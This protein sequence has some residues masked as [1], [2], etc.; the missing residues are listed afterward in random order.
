MKYAV[1]SS[2]LKF[3]ETLHRDAILTGY[4]RA[5]AATFSSSGILSWTE[6]TLHLHNPAYPP[7][8]PVETRRGSANENESSLFHPIF[9]TP[10]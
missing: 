2:T 5:F 4:L 3:L 8:E 10:L 9:T 1:T 6:R 7:A